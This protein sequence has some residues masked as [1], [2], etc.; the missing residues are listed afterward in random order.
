MKNMT[1][2]AFDS[3]FM[4]NKLLIASFIIGY[5]LQILVTELP[6]LNQAFKT[7]HLYFQDWIIITL[8]SMLPLVIHE[9]IALFLKLIKKK[10]HL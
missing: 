6:F 8:F 10:S 4:K 9:I 3:R 5:V 7:T 1:R 2:T